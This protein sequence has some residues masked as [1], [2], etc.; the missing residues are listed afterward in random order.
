VLQWHKHV[1]KFFEQC[2]NIKFLVKL[3]KTATK[4]CP[5]LEEVYK[6]SRVLKGHISKWHKQC[7]EE[8]GNV[9]RDSLLGQSITVKADERVGHLVWTDW[10]MIIRIIAKELGM[11]ISGYQIFTIT[12][13]VKRVMLWWCDKTWPVS[14]DYT[15]RSLHRS[16]RYNSS[17]TK[18]SF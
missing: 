4:T 17:G 16:F 3:K 2:I 6:E 10:R 18:I 1:W 5:L 12:L 14:N 13:K 7:S 9:H 15:R 8:W 11:D